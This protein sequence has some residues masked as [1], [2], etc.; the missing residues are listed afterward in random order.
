MATQETSYQVLF[1]VWDEAMPAPSRY[2]AVALDGPLRAAEEAPLVALFRW[3]ARFP[4]VQTT[5]AGDE[6][7]V[8][9]S[10]LRF[11]EVPGRR[12]PFLLKVIQE[13]GRSPVARW[14]G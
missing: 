8:S 4:V 14:G 9:F 2:P 1:S 5:R 3:F 13:P 7:I 11:G 6:T 12:R 10:D